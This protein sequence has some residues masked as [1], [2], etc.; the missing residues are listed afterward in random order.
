M[1][2]L[3]KISG[4]EFQTA[5][6]LRVLAPT[7][8]VADFSFVSPLL[9]G[10]RSA[11]QTQPCVVTTAAPF[12]SPRNAPGDALDVLAAPR[13]VRAAGASK[14]AIRQVSPPLHLSPSSHLK[15]DPVVGPDGS[16]RPPEC[17]L[18]STSAGACIDL[19]SA[20]P[21]TLSL[22]AISRTPSEAPLVEQRQRQITQR[23]GVT[24]GKCRA[25]RKSCATRPHSSCS[26]G[27]ISGTGRD[28]STGSKPQ[29]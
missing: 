1:R 3:A 8:R 24:G 15:A 22:C 17:V 26:W 25:Q 20:P 13:T 21:A 4:F 12:G 7:A 18:A 28:N 6:T 19:Q 16:P 9:R 2:H 10:D 5:T 29:A 11:D 27:E 14:L 23:S